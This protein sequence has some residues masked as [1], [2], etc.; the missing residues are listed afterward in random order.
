MPRRDIPG[1]GQYDV[2]G[3]IGSRK[4]RGGV[5]MRGGGG[6]SGVIQ[7]LDPQPGPGDYAPQGIC[8]KSHGSYVFGSA[9]RF[10]QKSDASP[11]PCE[12]TPRNPSHG[13]EKRT[14]LER[15]TPRRAGD[16]APGPGT[17]TPTASVEHGRCTNFARGTSRW[18][19]QASYMGLESPGP[20][21]YQ[22]DNAACGRR[23][24]AASFGSGPRGSIATTRG[25]TPGPGAYTWEKK[26]FGPKISITPR[27]ELE[28]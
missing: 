14:I 12:Y 13:A 1:P 22:Q 24:P 18:L 11:G 3:A 28:Y 19:S 5:V 20:A 9:N 25:P 8:D 2:P 10:G 15:G 4:A 16:I 26:P 17:Y 21:A 6:R 27:R 23:A 7:D